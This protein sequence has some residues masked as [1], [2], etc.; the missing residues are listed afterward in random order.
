MWTVY[1]IENGKQRLI[2]RSR[3]S[4]TIDDMEVVHKVRGKTYRV[5]NPSGVDVTA[6]FRYGT[7]T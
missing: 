4:P 5:L 2:Y 7:P 3:W 6:S 1:V